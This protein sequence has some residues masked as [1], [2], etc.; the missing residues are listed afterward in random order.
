MNYEN[1]KGKYNNL[2]ELD[3]K[4]GEF[5]PKRGR[6]STWSNGNVENM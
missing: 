4:G 6:I 5:S 1:V 2:G 3:W